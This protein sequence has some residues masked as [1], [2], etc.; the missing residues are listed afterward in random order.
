MKRA[1][2]IGQAM[3]RNKSDLHDW[4]TLNNW[5]YSIG[6]SDF[7][8]QLVVPVGKLSICYCLDMQFSQLNSVIGNMYKLD[9]YNLLEKELS[10][11]PLPHP[12]GA[13]IWKH[14]EKNREL[15]VEALNLL[16]RELFN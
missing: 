6:I 12:S 14:N 7:N 11:I 13:S 10:I 1:I 5:L 9:P 15:L 3:P 2:F 8:P 16:K 4:P